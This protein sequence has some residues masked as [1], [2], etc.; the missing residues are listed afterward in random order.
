MFYL[1]LNVG[2]RRIWCLDAH[3]SDPFLNEQPSFQLINLLIDKDIKLLHLNFLDMINEVMIVLNV[4]CFPCIIML[5][6]SFFR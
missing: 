3:Y 4:D 5:Q 2:F 6:W 1:H